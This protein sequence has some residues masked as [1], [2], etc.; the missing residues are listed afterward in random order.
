[1][2]LSIP[3]TMILTCGVPFADTAPARESRQPVIAAA[4]SS[5]PMVAA[6]IRVF[7]MMGRSLRMRCLQPRV[8]GGGGRGTPG[9]EAAFEQGEQPLREQG[10]DGDNEHSGVDAGGVEGALRVVDEQAE[11]LVGAGVL[12]HDGADEREAEGDVQAGQD[13]RGRAR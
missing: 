7:F 6:R 2:T 12:A 1:M 9:E 10:D 3:P 11:A 8:G 5:A 13:P 4:S